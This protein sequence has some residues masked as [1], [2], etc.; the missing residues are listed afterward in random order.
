MWWVA[1]WHSGTPEP[2]PGPQL[3]L[4]LQRCKGA[5]LECFP[6]SLGALPAPLTPLVLVSVG[7]RRRGI[8]AQCQL[9]PAEHPLSSLACQCRGHEWRPGS[10]EGSFHQMGCQVLSMV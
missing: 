7:R 3:I 2:Q 4:V 10:S 5:L 9:G 1:C 8:P 6:P